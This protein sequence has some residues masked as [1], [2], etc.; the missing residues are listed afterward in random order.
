MDAILLVGGFGT[1]LMPLTKT[2][3]KPLIPLANVPFVER[4]VCWLR[5]AGVD[6]VI[7]S[8]HYN[9]EQFMS[10]FSKLNLGIDMSFAVEGSPLGTG[11]AIKNCEPFLRSSRCYIFNG[12]I[13]TNIDL[14]KMLNAHSS[15]HAAVSIALYEVDDP[16]RFGVIET[17]QQGRVLSFTEKPPR[18]EARSRDINAG[19]YIFEREMFDWFPAGACSVERDIFPTMLAKGVFLLGYREWPY[20]TDLGTPRDYLQAHRDIL[21]NRVRIPLNYREITPGVWLGDQVSIASNALVRP[22]VIIGDGVTIAAGATVG[23]SVVLGANS[24]IGDNAQ[25][26]DSVLWEGVSIKQGSVVRESI[27]GQYAEISGEV[28]QG[29]CEDYGTLLCQKNQT[30][31]NNYIK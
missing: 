7:L 2:R 27:I 23:P 1:R 8:L 9:A 31:I 24:Y 28:V 14:T 10:H 15:A 29:I 12:D 4:T 26:E 17:D 19:V 18:E 3:P 11:G 30:M 22:P 25:V 20:W 16:S 6:H 13:F 21:S 5:D